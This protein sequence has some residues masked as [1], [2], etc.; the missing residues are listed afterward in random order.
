MLLDVGNPVGIIVV[1][2]GSIIAIV[3]IVIVFIIGIIKICHTIYKKRNAEA[4]VVIGAPA[5]AI[6]EAIAE[7]DIAKEEN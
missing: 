6:G 2:L 3:V 1:G 7:T 5:S 4:S